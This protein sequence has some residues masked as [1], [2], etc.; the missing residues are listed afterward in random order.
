LPAQVQVEPVPYVAS[1]IYCVL[2]H[3]R[4]LSITKIMKYIRSALSV[5]LVLGFVTLVAGV[6]GAEGRPNLSTSCRQEACCML[7]DDLTRQPAGP[8]DQNGLPSDGPTCDHCPCCLDAD[9][10]DP[11]TLATSSFIGVEL[12]IWEPLPLLAGH[13]QLLLKPPRP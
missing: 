11:M 12:S 2:Q 13:A 10:A 7:A 3:D 4:L 8:N 6:C 5:I 9:L 1:V